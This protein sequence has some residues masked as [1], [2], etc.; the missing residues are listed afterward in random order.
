MS[1][2][3]QKTPVLKAW[4]FTSGKGKRLNMAIKNIQR[5][6]HSLVSSAYYRT[7]EK[8]SKQKFSDGWKTPF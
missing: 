1:K 2:G 6:R 7:L 5:A 3:D 8:F 4:L